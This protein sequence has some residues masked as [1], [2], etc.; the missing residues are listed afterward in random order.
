LWKDPSKT[1][2]LSKRS[3]I[4]EI[5]TSPA[6]FTQQLLIHYLSTMFKFRRNKKQSHGSDDDE[7]MTGKGFSSG[8]SVDSR[9][10]PLHQQPQNQQQQQQ[11]A[12]AP[13]PQEENKKKISLCSE[14]RAR[15]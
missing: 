4:I 2:V 6:A 8:R 12:T 10:G 5:K 7:P 13:Q 3:R 14:D 11:R 9:S 1:R 15:R